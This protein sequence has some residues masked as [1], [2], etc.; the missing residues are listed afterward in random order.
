MKYIQD[1]DL[2]TF[3][4]E[5]T[6]PLISSLFEKNIQ[7]NLSKNPNLFSTLLNFNIKSLIEDGKFLIEFK[8]MKINSV[9]DEK[10]IIK[11]SVKSKTYIG[12]ALYYESYSLVSDVANKLA[13]E[14][15]I[16]GND[17]LGVCYYSIKNDNKYKVSLRG[18]N[19]NSQG[20]C[21]EIAEFYNGG[22]HQYSSA[23]FIE[24]KSSINF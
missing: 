11:I 23:F 10:K 21:S 16:D 18:H 12:Y 9:I 5:E 8:N 4:Y 17:N 14:S 3:N 6:E 13:R 15:L 7:F 2:Y 20:I 1:Y 22:G 19:K 24:K